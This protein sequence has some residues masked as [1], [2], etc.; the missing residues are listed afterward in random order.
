MEFTKTSSLY[1]LRY[2]GKS[3]MPLISSPILCHPTGSVIYLQY[4]NDVFDSEY[5]YAKSLSEV[6]PGLSND[7]H[8][9]HSLL[10]KNHSNV[11][12]TIT[13]RRH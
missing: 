5:I 3:D 10:L 7:W 12:T 6:P 9:D 2:H 1:T 4:Q 13:R 11:K 8:L